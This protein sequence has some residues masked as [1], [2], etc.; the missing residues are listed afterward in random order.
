MFALIQ[1]E[2]HAANKG[3][4]AGRYQFDTH[5]TGIGLKRVYSKIKNL[6]NPKFKAKTL[7]L[8]KRKHQWL[9]MGGTHSTRIRLKLGKSRNL[10]SLVWR[11]V[12]ESIIEGGELS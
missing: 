1:S 9:P 10:A 6:L 8:I 7:S 12:K 3:K 4:T 11:I 2:N 5:P